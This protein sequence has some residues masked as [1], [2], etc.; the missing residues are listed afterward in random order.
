MSCT[1]QD[2]NLQPSDG[3]VGDGKDKSDPTEA[4]MID[5]YSEIR[6]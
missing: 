3:G 5:F 6:C 1:V 2:L 4:A